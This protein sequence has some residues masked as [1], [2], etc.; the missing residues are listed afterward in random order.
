[1]A[2]G[3]PDER[4]SRLRQRADQNILAV[5]QRGGRWALAA[6]VR[7][8]KPSWARAR[9]RALRQ[10]LLLLAFWL[11]CFSGLS[12]ARADVPAE[13]LGQRVLEVRVV[14]DQAGR[15]DPSKLGIAKGVPLSRS[16]LRDAL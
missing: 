13:W 4:R 2:F 7:L 1:M 9:W 11:G 3:R 8:M 12:H 10:L 14:G 5:W 15:V 16:M 6:R